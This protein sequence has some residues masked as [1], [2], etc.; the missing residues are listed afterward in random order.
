MVVV[1]VYIGVP[2][3]A[4]VCTS[5]FLEGR[6]ELE[7]IVLPPRGKLLIAEHFD[8]LENLLCVSFLLLEEG[9]ALE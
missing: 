6:S 5:F 4:H 8:V 7:P 9:S 3:S 2:V 1:F